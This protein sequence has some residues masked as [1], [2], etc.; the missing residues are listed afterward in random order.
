[1]RRQ[2]FSFSKILSIN[3]LELIFKLV[4]PGMTEFPC[5]YPCQ[6][7]NKT[8]SNY[9]NGQVAMTWTFDADG[10]QSSMS[11]FGVFKCYQIT[12]RFLIVRYIIVKI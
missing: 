3:Y 4:F 6:W 12:E 9:K 8:L 7:Q 10:Q 1:M 2:T 11:S 5:Q